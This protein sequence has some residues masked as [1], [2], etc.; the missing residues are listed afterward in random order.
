[1]GHVVITGDQAGQAAHAFHELRLAR[2]DPLVVLYVLRG[3]TQGD[4]LRDLPQPL[5]QADRPVA[6]HILLLAVLV[7]VHHIFSPLVN[8]D[9]PGYPGLLIND[10]KWLSEHFC[11]FLQ[12]LCVDPVWPRRLLCV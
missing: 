12:Y 2:P 11:Q 10:A 1:M 5:G 3:G 4:L 7:A 9:L 6:P 8:W